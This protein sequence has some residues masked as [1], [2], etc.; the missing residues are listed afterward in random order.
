MKIAI[1]PL[2]GIKPY[3]RNPRDND[4][5][6]D[7]VAESIQRFGF[8]QPIVVDE[9]GV[10]VCGHT[11]WKAATKLGLDKVPVHVAT[12]L[13]PEQIRAYRI[14]DNKSGEVSTWKESELADEIDKLLTSVDFTALG[15]TSSELEALFAVGQRVENKGILPNPPKMAW[16]LIGIPL[17]RF[18]EIAEEYDR[19]SRINGIFCEA[20]TN[21]HEISPDG[22]LNIDGQGETEARSSSGSKG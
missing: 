15:F 7:A 8:R 10:I 4:A 5:A 22:Q 2:A 16:V 21:D 6:V 18:G 9:A 3:E 17:I 11:R 1:R 20:T 12:D 13:T 14:A 19:I